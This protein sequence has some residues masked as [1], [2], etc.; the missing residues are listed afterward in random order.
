MLFKKKSNKFLGLNLLTFTEHLGVD[1]IPLFYN[2][3]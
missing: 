1:L 2:T 3:N